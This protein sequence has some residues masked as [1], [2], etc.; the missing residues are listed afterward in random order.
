MD[1]FNTQ[2]YFEKKLSIYNQ[3]VFIVLLFNNSLQENYLAFTLKSWFSVRKK[4]YHIKMLLIIT[5][6]SIHKKSSQQW[7]RYLVIVCWVL[8]FTSLLSQMA[9]IFVLGFSAPSSL[10]IWLIDTCILSDLNTFL[11]RLVQ[12]EMFTS[13]YQ[14][15][16]QSEVYGNTRL[17]INNVFVLFINRREM[18]KN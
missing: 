10:L 11:E 1:H 15:L 4:S 17:T 8:K 5:V 6:C 16:F 3:N 2:H 18:A 13:G 14:Y 9:N 12:I 7:C